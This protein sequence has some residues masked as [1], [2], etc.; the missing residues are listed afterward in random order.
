MYLKLIAGN[1]KMFS[2]KGILV[3]RD[4]DGDSKWFKFLNIKMWIQKF[5]KPGLR[6]DFGCI[7][8]LMQSRIIG[9][10]VGK[11]EGEWKDGEMHGT[12]T[13][14]I[15][16]IFSGNMGSYGLAPFPFSWKLI[17]QGKYEGEWKNGKEHG[18]GIRFY[19]AGLMN[20]DICKYEGEWKDGKYHGQGTF[21]DRVGRKKKCWPKLSNLVPKKPVL[22][23]SVLKD[24][25][26]KY[27]LSKPEITQYEGEWK[28]GLEHGH[29]IRTSSNGGKIFIG[30]WKNG[31]YFHGTYFF[32]NGDK[33]FGFFKDGLADGHGI[34]TYSDGRKYSGEFKCARYHGQGTY[35]SSSG[36]KLVGRFKEGIPWNTTD[37]DKDQNF[38]GLHVQG[39]E[40]EIIPL[41]PKY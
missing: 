1:N 18:K 25:L 9:M 15:S 39:V 26:K 7:K 17:D 16:R 14:K 30:K 3:F 2:K 23:K 41:K 12:G 29:G 33:H 31:K 34:R 37:F 4:A 28:D 24:K 11:Y 40:R 21:I 35:Y 6:G 5:C 20:N 38:I 36:G 10:Y 27:T 13:L 19:R 32:A 22:E 8:P